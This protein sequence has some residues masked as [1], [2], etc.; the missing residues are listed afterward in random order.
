MSNA[1]ETVERGYFDLLSIKNEP[2]LLEVAAV[3]RRS[4]SGKSD[5]M[6]DLR[7]QWA[8]KPHRHVYDLCTRLEQA[9]ALIEQQRD[10]IARLREALQQNAV[11]QSWSDLAMRNPDN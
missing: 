3:Y 2:D 10:E 11:T 8:D 6:F 7:Y 4:L 9:A 1:D 5:D